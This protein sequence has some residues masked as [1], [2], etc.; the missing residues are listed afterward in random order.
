VDTLQAV[1]DACKGLDPGRVHAPDKAHTPLH[2]AVQSGQRRLVDMLLVAG[3]TL[4]N[5]AVVRFA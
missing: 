3:A 5:P 4:D 1:L 2:H